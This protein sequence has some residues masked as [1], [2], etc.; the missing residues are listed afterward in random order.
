MENDL[1][2]SICLELLE[3]PVMLPCSHNFCRK[4]VKELVAHGDF[5]CPTCRSSVGLRHRNIDDF[6]PNRA[7]GNIVAEYKRRHG[8]LCDEHGKRLSLFCLSCRKGVCR[9]CTHSRDGGHRGHSAKPLKNLCDKEKTRLA[10]ECD[11]LHNLV[12]RI[13]S[14][15]N[16]TERMEEIEEQ[17]STLQSQIDKTCQEL[18]SMIKQRRVA[19]KSMLKFQRDKIRWQLETQKGNIKAS[20]R[21]ID[22]YHKFKHLYDENPIRFLQESHGVFENARGKKAALKSI[23]TNTSLLKY[24]HLHSW[25]I[26]NALKEMTLKEYPEPPIKTCKFGPQTWTF[27]NSEATQSPAKS[28]STFVFEPWRIGIPTPRVAF[29][30]PCDVDPRLPDGIMVQPAGVQRPL[31]TKWNCV[32]AMKEYERFSFEEIRLEDYRC[33]IREAKR[34]PWGCC[35]TKFKPIEGFDTML[36]AGVTSTIQHVFF[37]LLQ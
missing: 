19:M 4:C 26:Q 2:C 3:S 8:H 31:T 29:K 7:L 16:P 25:K 21:I 24:K 37:V 5:K 14:S 28:S 22:K 17:I 15:F 11:A 32:T 30:P 20:Q 12:E 18:I 36:K 33:G 9:M 34:C 6:Q 27:G 10:E 23:D 1:T 13:N 35:V